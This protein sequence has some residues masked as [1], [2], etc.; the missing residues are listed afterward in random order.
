MEN[1][2]SYGKLKRYMK[3]YQKLMMLD[4]GKTIERD[5]IF[6]GSVKYVKLL[7]ITANTL[8]WIA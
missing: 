3:C 6:V 7:L 8:F 1:F 5:N 2:K 4:T